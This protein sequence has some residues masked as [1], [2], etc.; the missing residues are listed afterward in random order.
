MAGATPSA[1]ALRSDA[2]AATSSEVD[3][4]AGESA[5]DETHWEVAGPHDG[6]PIVFVHGAVMTR[7]QWTLQANRF[8]NAGYRAISIDLPGH[9]VLADR[10]FTLEAATEAVE[11]VIDRVAGG[12][13]VLVGLSLGGYVSMTVAAHSPE[14]VRGIVLAGSTREPTGPA[15]FAYWFVGTGLGLAPQSVLRGLMAF[16]WRRRYGPEIAAAIMAKGYWARGGGA[17]IRVLAGGGFRDRIRAYGGPIL[18]IN[19]NL[20]LVFRLGERRFLEG[21]P[22][23]TR[24]RISWAAHLSN[25]DRPD[26]FSNAVESFVETLAP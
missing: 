22:G 26:D 18:V 6:P 7:A 13:A 1:R 9:G 12:R 24:R 4:T 2:R 10:P 21:V 17:A 11:A 19:G 5:S 20:D 8:A 16:I 23:V 14:R 3:R 25:L 15:R